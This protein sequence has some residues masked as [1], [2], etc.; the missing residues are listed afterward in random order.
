MA[1]CDYGTIIKKNGII[2]NG[3]KV[4]IPKDIDEFDRYLLER[5]TCIGDKDMVFC[6]YKDW[7]NI[8]D[9]NFKKCKDCI[10]LDDFEDYGAGYS[11]YKITPKTI[12][13]VYFTG[14]RYDKGNR[15]IIKFKYKNDY[16]EVLFGYGVD[17]NLKYFYGLGGRAYSKY[18]R[19]LG[20]KI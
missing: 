15:Y 10:G 20:D 18:K 9:K 2:I 14:K 3:Y 6:F 8:F 11:N 4:N 17:C 16:Y 13:G 12:N 5:G 19:W 1:F 7:I